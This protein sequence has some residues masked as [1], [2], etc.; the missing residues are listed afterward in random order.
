MKELVKR[1]NVYKKM[2]SNC[3]EHKRF[4]TFYGFCFS[5]SNLDK[6]ENY[7]ELMKFKPN[8]PY[9]KQSAYWFY[10]YNYDIR[11]HILDIIIKEVKEILKTRSFK[12]KV[13]DFFITLF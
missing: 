4:H 5:L 11:L 12:E 13:K 7:P 3:K 9:Y 10:Y 6:I 2:Q 8:I 1:L